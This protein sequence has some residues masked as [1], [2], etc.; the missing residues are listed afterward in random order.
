MIH[1]ER[2]DFRAVP[3]KDP[4]DVRELVRFECQVSGCGDI[5]LSSRL[6]THAEEA[7]NAQTITVDATT[8]WKKEATVFAAGHEDSAVRYPSVH[9]T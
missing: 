6:A 3:A 1:V 2:V 4:L 7:H 9:S 5:V 8:L